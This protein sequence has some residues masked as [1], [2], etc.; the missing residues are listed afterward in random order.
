MKYSYLLPLTGIICLA[1][2][3]GS[4][5]VAEIPMGRL[6]YIADGN[7]RDSDDIA[8]IPIS[9]AILRAMGLE[10][11]LVHYSHS[12]DLVP[13]ARGGAYR[14]TELQISCDG[15]AERWGGFDHIKFL[16]AIKETDATVNDLVKHI[17]NSTAEDPLWIIEAGEPDVIVMAL[18]KSQ[19]DKR[20]FVHVIT[21]H[22]NNDKGNTF[23]L[24]DV[25]PLGVPKDNIHRIPD[26]NTLLRGDLSAMNWARD[27]K[28]DR[29]KW[30]Y[31]RV[32]ASQTP[33][34]DYPAIVGKADIS[35]AGMAWWWS[36]WDGQGGDEKGDFN[37]V[38]K[39]LEEH[40]ARPSVKTLIPGKK[41]N[42]EIRSGLGG[43]TL[44]GGNHPVHLEVANLQGRVI[45][46]QTGLLQ[47]S[48]IPVPGNR[49]HIVRI[50]QE[51]ASTTEAYIPK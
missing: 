12:C 39:L 2:G 41:G 20:K 16:N 35:D 5:A 26:Q 34:M 49:V 46:R 43:F 13:S 1:H 11:K 9:L 42:L 4:A 36:T 47:N 27:H 37:K 21:H 10:E 45:H 3:F 14:E 15:T 40:V 18:K 28:D 48:F 29:M 22:P 51:G 44:V 32:V 7:Y 50:S 23:N 25:H 8:A 24:E 19:Q 6:A 31:D 30:L 33:Q 17:D 38:R